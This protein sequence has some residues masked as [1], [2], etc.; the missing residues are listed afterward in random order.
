VNNLTGNNALG[1]PKGHGLA[2]IPD[3]VYPSLKW[4]EDDYARLQGRLDLYTDFIVLS[5]FFQGQVSEQYVVDPMEVAAVL[6][7]LDLSSGLLPDNCLFWSKK[8]GSD[9]LGIYVPPKVWLVAVR[10]EVAAWRVPLPGLVFTGH[11]YD[12]SVWAVAERPTDR[13]APVYLAPC[14]NVHPEG[15]CRGNAPFPRASPATIWQAV[16][17]FFSSKFNRDLSN[18]K[19]QAY[20]DCVLDQWRALHQAGT[21]SYPLTDLVKTNLSLGSLIDAKP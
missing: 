9:R 2:A 15:V 4:H 17:V 1:N 5:K 20:P 19:S 10:D 11:D 7:G 14:P 6:A 12:Y 21:E 18:H 16:D 3:L 8:H 13:Q